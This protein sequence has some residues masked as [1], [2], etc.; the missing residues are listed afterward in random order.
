MPAYI[1][2]LVHINELI[3]TTGLDHCLVPVTQAKQHITLEIPQDFINHWINE[4]YSHLHFGAIRL[5]LNFHGRQNI[6][7]ISRMSLLNRTF[8][9]YEHVVIRSAIVTLNS[10]NVMFTFYPK[11]NIHLRD[12]NLSSALQIQIQIQ[13]APQI[14]T[15]FAG[16]IHH[17]LI[18]RV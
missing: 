1:S 16:T 7:A 12:P 4:K 6:T 18:Y 2:S 3:H 14:G 17:Q 11:F 15:A 10:G 8:R 9:I 13:G 5:I